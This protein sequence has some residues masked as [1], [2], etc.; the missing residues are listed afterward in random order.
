M[1]IESWLKDIFLEGT[2]GD[3]SKLTGATLEMYN[4]WLESLT[5]SLVVVNNVLKKGYYTMEEKELLNVL[6]KNWIEEKRASIKV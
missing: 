3:G 4:N 2:K 6:R 1:E 5:E